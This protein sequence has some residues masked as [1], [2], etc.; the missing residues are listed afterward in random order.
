MRWTI[1]AAL[2]VAGLGA[3]N[4]PSPYLGSFAVDVDAAAADHLAFM[5]SLV[6]TTNPADAEKFNRVMEAQA[7]S[8]AQRDYGHA[9]L[10]LAPDHTFSWTHGDKGGDVVETGTWDDSEARPRAGALAGADVLLT[11]AARNGQPVPDSPVAGAATIDGK[12]R[13]LRRDAADR[14]RLT[15][16]FTTVVGGTTPTLTTLVLRRAR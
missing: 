13:A 8:E 1:C 11:A 10:D 16:Q 4:H 12:L 14:D 2:A 3:C 7:R 9:H 15:L 6:H 5:K